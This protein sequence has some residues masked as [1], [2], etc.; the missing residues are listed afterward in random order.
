MDVGVG[1][2][3]DVEL[4][5]ARGDVRGDR[6]VHRDRARRRRH[7]A[8]ERVRE[9]G[10]AEVGVDVDVHRDVVGRPRD[11]AVDRVAAA[12]GAPG[13]HHAVAR[14]HAAVADRAGADHQVAGDLLDRRR[15]GRQ[16]GGRRGHRLGADREAD[17]GLARGLALRAGAGERAELLRGGRER[18]LLGRGRILLG[19]EVGAVAA[20]GDDRGGQGERRHEPSD[21]RSDKRSNGRQASH[22]DLPEPR[23]PRTT[24][25][26]CTA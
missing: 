3:V 21:E 17:R 12:V 4:G 7:R 1:V 23:A 19:A 6:H 11:R 16:R 24:A 25:R 26:G 5:G 13:P 8:G 9:L 14:H 20:A 10:A 15:A 2:E 18:G 22:R